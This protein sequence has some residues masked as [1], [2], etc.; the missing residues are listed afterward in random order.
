MRLGHYKGECRLKAVGTKFDGR[1]RNGIAKTSSV[2]CRL[3]KKRPPVVKEGRF[4]ISGN[5][6]N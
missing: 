4:V 3:L 2:E 1:E 6:Q 5:N